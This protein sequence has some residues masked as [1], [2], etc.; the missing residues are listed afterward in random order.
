LNRTVEDMTIG[1]AAALT[2]LMAS[3]DCRTVCRPLQASAA[4]IDPAVDDSRTVVDGRGWSTQT[5]ESDLRTITREGCA[6][7]S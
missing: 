7:I 2:S 1:F 5:F 3:W 6:L 4:V